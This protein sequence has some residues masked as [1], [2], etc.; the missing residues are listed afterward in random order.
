MTSHTPQLDPEQ[1]EAALTALRAGQ[2]PAQFSLDPAFQAALRLHVLTSI[3]RVD[4]A[5]ADRIKQQLINQLGQTVRPVGWR[6]WVRPLVLVPTGG[7]LAAGLLV[8]VVLQ[9]T[10]SD[11]NQVAQQNATT[12]RPGAPTSGSTGV[13]TG[14]EDTSPTSQSDSPPSTD[15]TGDN[16]ELNNQADPTSVLAAVVSTNTDLAKL[17]VELDKTLS[18]LD[19]LLDQ[20]DAA[21]QAETDFSDLTI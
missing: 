18:E 12:Q 9:H 14:D 4:P 15:S 6:R 1:L 10:N 8:A 5:A 2:S 7:V 21:G 19:A 3:P 16:D 20:V 17:Q 13:S 11:A